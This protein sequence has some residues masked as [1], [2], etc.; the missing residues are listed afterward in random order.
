M[1]PVGDSS[2]RSPFISLTPATITISEKSLK[3]FFSLTCLLTTLGVLSF[4]GHCNE[5]LI[6]LFSLIYSLLQM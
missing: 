2:H 5:F 3:C 4:M 6:V 1:E